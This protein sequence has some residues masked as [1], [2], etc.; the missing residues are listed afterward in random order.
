[1][2]HQAWQ[3]ILAEQAKDDAPELIV[4]GGGSAT[5]KSTAISLLG[6]VGA[7]KEGSLIIDDELIRALIPELYDGHLT[8]HPEKTPENK[9]KY[10]AAR[11]QM[12][13]DCLRQGISIV[14]DDHCDDMESIKKLMV[15]VKKSHAK[16]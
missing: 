4:L 12:V 1:L 14:L 10:I 16:V 11:N 5:G 13:L 15:D 3:N 9:P 8:R 7:I 2:N 6:E